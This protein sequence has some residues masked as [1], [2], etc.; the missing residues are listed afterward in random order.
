MKLTPNAAL[1]NL[2]DYCQPAPPSWVPQTIGWYAL[3]A[4]VGLSFLWLIGSIIHGWFKDRYR[5]EALRELATATPS[6]FSALLKRT[7]LCA[8]PRDK[9][10]SLSGDAW[11]RFLDKAVGRNLFQ[12]APCNRIEGMAFQKSTASTEEEQ[13]L[14]TSVAEWIRRHRVQA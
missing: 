10:A 13:V 2:H 7:A 11:L 8:W 3:F 5:R 4:V 6:Q 12:S 9:V 14:R 1:E